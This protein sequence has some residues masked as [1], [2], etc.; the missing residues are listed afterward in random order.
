M[1]MV[2]SPSTVCVCPLV[3]HYLKA[4]AISN[5]PI[6]V[7]PLKTYAVYAVTNEEDL[8]VHPDGGYI[9]LMR[10]AASRI[11]KAWRNHLRAR[12]VRYRTTL[13]RFYNMGRGR[14]TKGVNCNYAHGYHDVRP[15]FSY[16]NRLKRVFDRI[17][18][19]HERIPDLSTNE[20]LSLNHTL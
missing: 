20:C 4:I 12:G 7:I 14:C 3:R 2:P 16:F 13:C 5:F 17:D 11:Q 6:E 15:S 10:N 18:V 1:D 8:S 19:V 9:Q